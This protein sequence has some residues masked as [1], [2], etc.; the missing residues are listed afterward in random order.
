MRIECV[1]LLYM[2][3][4]THL[5][6]MRLNK[7]RTNQN[8]KTGGSP[9][10]EDMGVVNTVSYNSSLNLKLLPNKNFSNIN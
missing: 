2:Y 8:I 5:Y 7:W 3:T 4:H 9:Y 1:C 10:G 6:L